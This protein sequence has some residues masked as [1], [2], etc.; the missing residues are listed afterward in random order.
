MFTVLVRR[1]MV[2]EASDYEEPSGGGMRNSTQLV[3]L[4]LRM[5]SLRGGCS[6]L[7]FT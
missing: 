1:P 5:L 4:S 7:F 3:V 6:R 2:K